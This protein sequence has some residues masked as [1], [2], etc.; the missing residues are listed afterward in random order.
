MSKKIK[1]T[2]GDVFIIKLLN[3]KFCV[4]QILDLQMDNIVR[5]SLFNEVISNLVTLDL[6]KI[7]QLENLIS[8][9]AVS[10]ENLDNGTWKIEGNKEISIP[11][12]MFPNE[13]FRFNG[14]IGS[15]VY[16]SGLAED[17]L[18]SFFALLPWDDWHDPNFLDEFLVD[19]K[20]K[21]QNLIFIKKK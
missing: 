13:K 4:G 18:N 19:K 16:D 5:V 12:S 10:R 3:G 2:Y 15:V 1:W 20:M 17:F 9:V 7:C 8:L 14:W 21:P 6:S 11:L